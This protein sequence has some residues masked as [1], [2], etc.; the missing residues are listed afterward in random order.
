MYWF[1]FNFVF[2]SFNSFS[3]GDKV[4]KGRTQNANLSCL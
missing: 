1:D 2:S 3:A 4:P